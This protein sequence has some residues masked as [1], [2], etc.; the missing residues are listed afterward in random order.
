MSRGW[1]QTY[2]HVICIIGP[3][4]IFCALRR[5]GRKA[6]GSILTTLMI[7]GKRTRQH[8]KSEPKEPSE[9]D[10]RIYELH[11]AGKTAR[12]VAEQF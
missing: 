2:L 7:E 8:L 3:V 10:V 6:T 9:R 4:P 1:S 11:I 12:E 5:S